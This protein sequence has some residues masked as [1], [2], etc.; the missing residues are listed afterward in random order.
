M[1]TT[2]IS[3]MYERLRRRATEGSPGRRDG[4][5]VLRQQGLHAWIVCV[6]T[7]PSSP[8][9]ADTPPTRG[10]EPIAT[11]SDRSP[12]VCLCTDMLLAALLPQEAR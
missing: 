6:T 12:L 11:A 8:P 2:E 3:E 5:A 4:L 10:P 1:S 9:Q 7:G